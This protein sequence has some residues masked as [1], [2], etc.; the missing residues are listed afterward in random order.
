MNEKWLYWLPL[1]MSCWAYVNS[2]DGELVHDDLNAIQFN[3]DVTAEDATYWD[4]FSNDFWGTSM[5]DDKSHKSYRP[6][7]VLS[8]RFLH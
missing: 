4:I 7:T 2:I 3:G 5:D 6:L 8:F 1:L